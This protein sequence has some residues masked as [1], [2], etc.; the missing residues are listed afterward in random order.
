MEA[1]R[2]GSNIRRLGLGRPPDQTG[3][4]PVRQRKVIHIDMDAFF[5]S[6]EQ[7]DNPELRG[8]PVAVGGSSERGVSRSLAVRAAAFSAMDRPLVPILMAASIPIVL[9]AGWISVQAANEERAAARVAA[10]F[11]DAFARRGIGLETLLKVSPTLL[12]INEA[13]EAARAK[14]GTYIRV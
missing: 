2:C 8:K 12:P 6:V 4:E 9:F 3:V 14:F 13:A 5:A 11:K 1:E 7:R 10:Y